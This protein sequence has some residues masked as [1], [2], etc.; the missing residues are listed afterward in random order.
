MRAT[1]RFHM[2][3]CLMRCVLEGELRNAE[4]T[5]LKAAINTA[6]AEL[7]QA[8]D[9]SEEVRAQPMRKLDA[10]IANLMEAVVKATKK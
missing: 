8:D 2:Q 10:S 5:R 9:S 4:V 6:K 3:R 7:D 1:L